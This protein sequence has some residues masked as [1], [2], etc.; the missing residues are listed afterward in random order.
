MND[1][2]DDRLMTRGA[3]GDDEAF[4]LLVARW[5]DAVFGFLVRM[6]GN[7]EEAQDLCQD[8]M[9]RVIASAGGYRPDGRFRS[10]LFRIAGNLARN[11]LRRRRIVRWLSIDRSPLDP[12]LE[13]PDTLQAMAD[14]ETLDAVR[15]AIAKLPV[16]Q[17]EA[18]ILRV[19]HEMRYDEIAQA[20][21]VT[22]AS[23]QMLL[24]RAM[25]VLRR[26]LAGGR[27][28]P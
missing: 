11:R 6:L 16:R 26:D 15:R 27:E 19:D 14:R 21:G 28:M 8:T 5:E 7:R 2:S 17:R 9:C 23:V 1:D 12:P 22:V 13:E 4:S 20:M 18:L 24:H 3:E 25:S 10:W